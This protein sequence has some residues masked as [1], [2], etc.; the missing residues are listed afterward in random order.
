MTEFSLKNHK[1]YN[2]KILFIMFEENTVINDEKRIDDD[3][4]KYVEFLTENDQ[5]TIIVDARNVKSA[6]SSLAIRKVGLFKKIEPLV[7]KN[8]ISCSIIINNQII[9]TILST[10][11]KMQPFVVPYKTVS[12]RQQAMEFCTSHF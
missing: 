4:K 6:S 1:R 5:L 7:K 10:L 8:V 2:K 9:K 3:F 11:T 12:D